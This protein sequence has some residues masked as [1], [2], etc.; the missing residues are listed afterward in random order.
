MKA[1]ITNH[2]LFIGL[3]ILLTTAPANAQ[4]IGFDIGLSGSENYGKPNTSFGISLILPFNENF[5]GTLSFNQWRGEDGNYTLSKYYNAKGSVRMSGSFY[6]NKGLNLLVNY[7]Y[8]S[9]SNISF[10]CGAGLG[11]FEMLEW[12]ENNEVEKSF[13][14]AITIVPLYVKM[15]LSERS[16]IYARGTLSAKTNKLVPDWGTINFG[17]EFRPF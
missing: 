15:S 10:L 16:R 4:S 9:I 11:Q 8:Y 2:L 1:F 6:G 12:L 17:V 13:T 5:E 7:K 14:G 3:S